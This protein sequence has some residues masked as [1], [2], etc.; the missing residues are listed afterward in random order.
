LRELLPVEITRNAAFCYNFY[1]ANKTVRLKRGKEKPIR[2]KHHWIFSGA[3][4]SLPTFENGDLLSVLSF[5]NEILG[6]A[7]FNTKGSIIGRMVAFGQEEALAAI[8]RNIK[9]AAELRHSLFADSETD[10][11]RLINAE[12]DCLP[13]LVVDKYADALCMQISTKGMERLRAD[14]IAILTKIFKPTA[15]YEKSAIPSRKEEGLGDFKALHYGTLPAEIK[16]KE[17]GLF[18]FVSIE[19]GQKTGFFLDQREMRKEI[20]HLA[21]GK[22]VLNAF[23]YTG[24]FTVSAAAGGAVSVDS[25][26]VSEK[27]L[28]HGERN[29]ELNRLSFIPCHFFQEDVFQFLREKSLPYDLVILDPPAFVKRQKDLIQGC[30]GYKDINRLAMLKMPPKS[31]LLTSSCSY[32]VDESLFQKVI[33][34]AATEAGRMA[35]IIG[36]HKLAPD[37]PVNLCHPEGDYLKSLLLYLE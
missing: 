2:N 11:Y 31:F 1:M 24:G 33:F 16:I 34:Q 10:S 4:E 18:F 8:A 30:R 26:D 6:T 27:A 32:Y 35:K 23:S 14:L 20:R 25:V 29:L 22:R 19:E 9:Q 36:R 7:Y 37:H 13:G 17:N 28:N 21:R 3:V 12:G 5:D 15:L